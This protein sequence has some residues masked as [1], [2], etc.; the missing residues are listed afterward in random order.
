M[1]T[2]TSI[3]TNE[4]SECSDN[5]YPSR[6]IKLSNSRPTIRH[7][8][9][10]ERYSDDFD[11]NYSSI[12][13]NRCGVVDFTS[14]RKW[15]Q[16]EF[17]SGESIERNEQKR[18][19]RIFSSSNFTIP[20]STINS[21]CNDDARKHKW[22]HSALLKVG[23]PVSV[24]SFL[25]YKAFAEELK[26]FEGQPMVEIEPIQQRSFVSMN[27]LD[28]FDYVGNAVRDLVNF[29][30]EVWNWFA[31]FKENI[32]EISMNLLITVFDF[33]TK[34]TLFTPTYLFDNEWFKANVLSFLG[35]S[36]AG[37]IGISIFEGFKRMTRDVLPTKNKIEFTDMKRIASRFPLAL[38]GSILAP[39]ILTYGFQAIN[40]LTNVIIGLG[41]S[42]M[43]S[44]ISE[45]NF[46][47]TTLLETL[48][49]FGFT[50]AI[51]YFSIPIILANFSRWFKLVSLSMLSPLIMSSWIFKSTEHFFRDAW[52]SFKK[53]G[54]TQ[55]VYSVFLLIISSLLFA[56]KSP[57]NSWDLLVKLGIT[58][59]AFNVM[60]NS[61]EYIGKYI[62]KGGDLTS[63]WKGAGT[64][65]TPNPDV[66]KAI[67][68]GDKA[69]EQ[70]NKVVPKGIKH[71]VEKLFGKKDLY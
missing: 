2:T 30:G 8:H 25:P 37:T 9:Y 5:K 52:K 32:A 16:N 69:G 31:N 18:N 19:T 7:K 53:N 1:S 10:S 29:I 50:G 34:I 65:L 21:V 41:K 26:P 57:D 71:R 64:A 70:L 15:N 44:S 39:S 68:F 6:K 60:A 24:L 49:Y 43:A 4:T 12:S 56:T 66:K 55:I 14:D 54:F 59:G 28:F 38:I 63:M 35:L 20:Y 27:P 58:V 22:W 48:T 62:S 17:R 67:D 23:I 13:I 33:I 3:P 40:W 46:N 36:I 45:F 51:V 42:N 11:T 47:T 61:H